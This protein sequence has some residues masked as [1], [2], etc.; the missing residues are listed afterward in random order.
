MR[1]M[2]MLTL[3]PVRRAARTFGVKSWYRLMG[4]ETRVGKKKMKAA[5]L[6]KSFSR[7]FPL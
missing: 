3:A 4:P 5:Y 2:P 7:I 6:R 1:V